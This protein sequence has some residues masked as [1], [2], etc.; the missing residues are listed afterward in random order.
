MGQAGQQAACMLSASNSR[1]WWGS[2]THVIPIHYRS[3][4]A[5]FQSF[6]PITTSLSSSSVPTTVPIISCEGFS[7]ATNISFQSIDLQ[8]YSL[9]MSSCVDLKLSNPKV[10]LFYNSFS[11]CRTIRAEFIILNS[12]NTNWKHIYNKPL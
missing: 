7:N 11:T 3:T 10:K 8:Q 6:M 2:C 4:W 12:S 9:F 1:F 5:I